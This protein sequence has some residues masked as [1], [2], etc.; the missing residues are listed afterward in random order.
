MSRYIIQVT[1]HPFGACGERPRQVL[2]ATGWQIRYNPYGR[3]LKPDEVAGVV[4]HAHGLVAGTEPYTREVLDA[5]PE[6]KVISRVGVGL[7]NLDFDLLRERGI[8]ATFTPEAPADGVAELAVC[9]ILNLL[10][11][12]HD[13][14]KSV[15]EGLWNRYL[16]WLVREVKIGVLGVGRIGRRVVRLLQPFGARLYG[17]DLKP[18]LEFGRQHGLEW[19]AI[20][21]LFRTCNLVTIHVPLNEMNTGLVGAAELASMPAGG[22]LVNTARGRIV[23]EAALVQALEGGRLAGAA[24][25]VFEREPYEGP[26]TQFENVVLTAHMG[27]SA[28][29]SRY[30]MELGAAEDCVRVLSG[31][32]PVNPVTD[33]DIP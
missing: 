4:E 29:G 12:V 26:L 23:D 32:P 9:Q 20:R 27:A 2:E 16:G 3:R 33:E 24:V 10:R 5:A 6:L 22:F 13:S 1:T 11:K 15:R 30:L 17:C 7:D 19:L 31:K 25:D 21:E 28:R 8:V 14:D 18:D